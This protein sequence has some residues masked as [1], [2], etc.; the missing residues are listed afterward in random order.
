MISR[1]AVLVAAA[2]SGTLACA[3][4][5]GLDQYEIQ[6]GASDANV[7]DGGDAPVSVADAAS[8]ADTTTVADATTD[9]AVATGACKGALA[10]TRRVFVT[11]ATFSGDLGGIAG[12][13][14]KCNAA[15]LAST[16]A[17]LRGRSYLPWLSDGNGSVVGRLPHGTAP[18]LRAD[19]LA[20][21]TSFGDLVDA[22]LTNPLAMD[23]D[24]NVLTDDGFDLVWTATNPSGASVPESCSN[25]SVGTIAQSGKV[26]KA[27][28]PSRSW[29][30][31]SFA[32]CQVAAHL[33]CI[34][35]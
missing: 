2:F 3:S 15:A 16:K 6:D 25:W 21:A 33:Y 32:G 20:V 26:G 35:H 29:T 13:T 30:E 4:V 28:T 24:G 1:P 31:W 19:D 10:C 5:I 23:E 14:A 7:T 11:K 17:V 8:V 34:E 22:A 12:A 18:Y 9:S 27:S